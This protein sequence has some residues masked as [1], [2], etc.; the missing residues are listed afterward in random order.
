MKKELSSDERRRRNELIIIVVIVILIIGLTTFMVKIPQVDD[1]SPIATNIIILGL[2]NINII[3][4]LLLI[5]LVI[6]NLV[7]LIFERKREVLGAKLRTKLVLAF[8]LLSLVPT[9][10]LF[11]VAAGFITNSV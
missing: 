9:F 2:I 5:F 7:K 11:F 4:I 6:R 10:L 8:I 1:R 3:L